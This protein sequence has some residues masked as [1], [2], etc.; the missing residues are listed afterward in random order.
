M[1][2]RWSYYPAGR[3]LELCVPSLS[4]VLSVEQHVSV[5]AK[6]QLVFRVSVAGYIYIHMTMASWCGVA[7]QAQVSD[8]P[9]PRCP[10]LLLSTEL[11]LA[12]PYGRP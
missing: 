6:C 3:V 8:P 11:I 9:Q 12:P 5:D 10:G 4:E 7:P 1:L 2:L